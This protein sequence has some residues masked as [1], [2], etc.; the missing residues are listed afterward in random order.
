MQRVWCLKKDITI[1]NKLKKKKA[2]NNRLSL[3]VCKEMKIFKN[4]ECRT[5]LNNIFIVEMGV[6][7]RL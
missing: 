6:I 2:F 4:R 3:E 5:V 7:N 1:K